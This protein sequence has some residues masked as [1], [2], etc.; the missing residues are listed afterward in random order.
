MALQNRMARELQMLQ[1]DP[2]PG[3]AA[4][5]KDDCIQQVQAQVQGPDDSVYAGGVFTLSVNIPDRWGRVVALART[6]AVAA[7]PSSRLAYAAS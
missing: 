2:P 3:V 1:L 6:V 4:W 5:P 7:Q